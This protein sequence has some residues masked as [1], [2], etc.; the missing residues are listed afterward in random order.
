[1]IDHPAHIENAKRALAA[2]DNGRTGA[3]LS[4]LAVKACSAL[5]V[6]LYEPADG[7][8]GYH[9]ESEQEFL[10]RVHP[11]ASDQTDPAI[12]AVTTH[13]DDRDYGWTISLY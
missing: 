3:E 7:F 11:M 8:Q 13:S 12:Q 9:V 4:A 6:L 1:M 2:F 5:R 10:D